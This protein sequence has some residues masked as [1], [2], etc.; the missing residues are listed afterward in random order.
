M[1]LIFYHGTNCSYCE[2]AK[3]NLEKVEK[4]LGIKFERKEIWNN[5]TNKNEFVSV[6]K[7]KLIPS[8]YNPGTKDIIPRL[9]TYEEILAWTKKQLSSN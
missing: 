1:K 2:Q 8:L 3:P 7:E 5:E 9:I 4:E 6:A